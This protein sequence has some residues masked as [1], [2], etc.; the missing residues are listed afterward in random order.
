M[1]SI[2]RHLLP[3]IAIQSGS[4]AYSWRA[5]FGAKNWLQALKDLHPTEE[6]A[7]P[8]YQ[9]LGI[10][11]VI[12]QQR[13]VGRDVFA[14]TQ[15]V[16]DGGGTPKITAYNSQSIR[17]LLFHGKCRRLNRLFEECFTISV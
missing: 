1:V 8:V 7:F 3:E 5:S 10:V 11:K 14:I 6:G 2:C 12:N 9:T 16:D 4:R 13:M 15:P 17:S